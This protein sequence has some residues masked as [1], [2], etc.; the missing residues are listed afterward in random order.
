MKQLISLLLIFAIVPSTQA[1]FL[2]KIKEKAKNAVERKADQT[3]DKGI[4]KTEAAIDKTATDALKGNSEKKDKPVADTAKA[5]KH[6]TKENKSNGK[7][8]ASPPTGT[9]QEKELHSLYNPTPYQKFEGEVPTPRGA[10]WP[11]FDGYSFFDEVDGEGYFVENGEPS[12]KTVNSRVAVHYFKVDKNLKATHYLSFEVGRYEDGDN[13]KHS[14]INQG[15][16]KKDGNI[17]GFGGQRNG[18]LLYNIAPDGKRTTLAGSSFNYKKIKDGKGQEAWIGFDAR[19][20]KELPDGSVLFQDG[21]YEVVHESFPE[22]NE[23]GSVWRLIT[24]DGEIK[25]VT[26][27]KGKPI[28][29]RIFSNIIAD[30]EGY[31]YY[32]N[33]YEILK[34]KPGL[35]IDSFISV[36]KSIYKNDENSEYE[37]S[38]TGGKQKWVMGK[39]G[40]A[41]F[42]GIA[43]I[44]W[45]ANGEIYFFSS[46]ALR[47]A[48]IS[49]KTVTHFCGN[50]DFT[51]WY[52]G[53]SLGAKCG[54]KTE[55][56]WGKIEQIDGNA[57]TAT[58]CNVISMKWIGDKLVV[59]RPA[60]LPDPKKPG[61]VV[62][63]YKITKIDKAG[64]AKSLPTGTN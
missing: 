9:Y 8:T 40:T 27:A 61:Y 2:N 45:G 51:N 38:K 24:P 54:A 41:S 5:E 47:L 59:I 50:S 63:S 33:D 15:L 29:K 44:A 62:K 36:A 34:F 7:K 39:L 17:L 43:K 32:S 35:V 25:T 1:Q 60:E 20:I 31:W 16:V 48:V 56:V 22:M 23:T 26:D 19:M 6:A 49:N 21:G 52:S 14:L 30:K 12:N 28:R 46:A 3:I 58:I 4:S 57:T 64:N 11:N 42:P 18:M 55:N 37:L 13:Y 10:I 53:H